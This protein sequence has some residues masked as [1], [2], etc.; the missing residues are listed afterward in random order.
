MV[1]LFASIWIEPFTHAASITVP[2]V[3]MVNAPIGARLEPVTP[4][5][6]EFGRTAGRHRVSIHCSFGAREP[7]ASRQGEQQ[8]LLVSPRVSRA[9]RPEWWA[10]RLAYWA[11]P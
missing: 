3:L 7:Q 11:S 1:T 5:F 9:R 4:T 8:E 2:A 6:D 10:Q